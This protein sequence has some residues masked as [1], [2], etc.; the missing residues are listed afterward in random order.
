LNRYI[1]LCGETSRRKADELI[2][3]GA[4]SV[5]GKIVTELGIKIDPEKDEVAVSGKPIQ[6]TKRKLY[7]L[8][9]KPKDVLTTSADELN[10]RTVLDLIGVSERIYPVGR[11]DRDTTGVLLLTNDGELAHRLMHP[12]YGVEKEY[13]A[14]L[15]QKCT[16]EGIQKLK[17]GFRLKDT[18]EKVSPCNAKIL[19]DG[20]TIW[21]SIHEGKNHQVH[22]MF[23]TLGYNVKKLVRATYGG[24]GLG[25]LKRGEW[26]SLIPKEVSRLY[27]MVSLTTK[28]FESTKK[29]PKQKES[30]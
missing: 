14:T 2:A 27:K 22:R 18:G 7:I 17:A 8:L 15:D 30:A 10:R 28:K 9:H 23:W 3:D 4:V 21:L 26:R 5:N 6:Q 12:S 11:L 1:S 20:H 19:D 25:N 16:K 24:I 13:V 29:Q